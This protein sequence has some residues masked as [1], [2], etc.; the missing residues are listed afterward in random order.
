[1]APV[2]YELQSAIA[3]HSGRFSAG[4]AA[5]GTPTPASG[6]ER[7]KFVSLLG[8]LSAAAA[9][10]SHLGRLLPPALGVAF[11][12]H[13]HEPLGTSVAAGFSTFETAPSSLASAHMV[14]LLVAF[15]P[16]STSRARR[17]TSR[18]PGRR[19]EAPPLFRFAG[20]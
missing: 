19:E 11:Y 3:S 13:V 17:D 20:F 16:Y 15:P 1:M 2:L 14:P 6:L 10:L 12:P 8:Y 5:G 4:P 7:L 18:R 9:D